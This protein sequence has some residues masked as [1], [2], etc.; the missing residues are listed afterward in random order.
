MIVFSWRTNYQEHVEVRFIFLLSFSL[1]EYA[2]ANDSSSSFVFS[3]SPTIQEPNRRKRTTT[4]TKM[5]TIRTIRMTRRRTCGQWRQHGAKDDNDDN[6]DGATDNN[7]KEDGDGVTDDDGDS[8]GA[9]DDDDD[10]VDDS[11]DAAA[12]DDDVDVDDIDND[13]LPPRIGKRNDGCNETKKKEEETVGD[14]H[15]NQTDHREGGG[16]WRRL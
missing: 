6:G 14:T 3:L 5:T 11:N 12:D 7:G 16:R 15:N 9:T 2:V 8:N 4:K 13:N 1:S 10:D